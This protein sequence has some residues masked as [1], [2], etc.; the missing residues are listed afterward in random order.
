VLDLVEVA[1]GDDHHHADP[2]VEGALHLLGGDGPSPLDQAEEGRHLPRAPPQERPEPLGEDPRDVAGEAPSGDVGEGAHLVPLEERLEGGEVASVGR[3]EGFAHRPSELGEVR[4]DAVAKPLEEH[5]AGEGVAV[6]VE[7]GRGQAEEDVPLPHAAREGLLLLDHPHDEAGEVVVVLG[8]GARHLRGLA[9]DERAAELDAGPG[10]AGHDL[11]DLDGIHLPEGNVVEEEEG[12]GALDED[13]VHAVG[14]EVIAHGVVHPGQDRDL[15]LGPHPVR[16]GHEH[17]LAVA[18]EVRAEH[19]AEGADL[20]ENGGV[21][22][23]L[24]QPLDAGLGRVR[25]GDVDAGLPVVHGTLESSAKPADAG[26]GT[27]LAMP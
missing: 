27:P 3:E 16:R 1:R 7:A 20:G 22:A 13:V 10:E 21:E 17:R 11:L 24:G 18:R 14:D 5:L 25:G 2:H 6:R 9:A 8:V 23:G 26:G 12:L 15:D 19:P 4:V